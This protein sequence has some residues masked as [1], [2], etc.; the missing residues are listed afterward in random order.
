[1]NP[2]VDPNKSVVVISGGMDSSTLLLYANQWSQVQTGIS[3]NYGQR[4]KTELNCAKAQ[5]E[6]LGIPHMTIDLQSVGRHLKSALTGTEEVPHGHYAEDNMRATIVPNRNA[7]MLNIA[8]GIAISLGAGRVYAGMHSGDHAVY[9]DCRPEFV[10]ALNHML[11]IATGTEIRVDTPFI[12]VDK[13]EIVRVGNNLGVN[14]ELTWSCYEGGII[15]CGRCGTCVERAEAFYLAN[16]EDPTRYADN[17][18]WKEQV[19][20]TPRRKA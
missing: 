9:P 6:L 12:G 4:H 18:F 5:C 15:H 8:A 2:Q 7:I 3:F 17:E 10:S 1:M 19:G 16:I 11:Q 14:W 13:A 20:A